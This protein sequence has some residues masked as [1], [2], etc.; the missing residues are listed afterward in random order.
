MKLFEARSGLFMKQ[1]HLLAAR[2][3]TELINAGN[4]VGSWTKFFNQTNY[5]SCWKKSIFLEAKLFFLFETLSG[6]EVGK[7][8]VK[9]FN[10]NFILIFDTD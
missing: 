4:E 10:L 9:V 5:F 1:K 6:A 8:D 3:K 2:N 7:V